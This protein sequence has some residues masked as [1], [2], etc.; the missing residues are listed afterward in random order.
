[1][2]IGL[3]LDAIEV[4]RAECNGVFSADG[5]NEV[6]LIGTSK[7]PFA[8]AERSP[9]GTCRTPSAAGDLRENLSQSMLEAIGAH[10]DDLWRSGRALEVGEGLLAQRDRL[11]GAARSPVSDGEAVPRGEAIQVVGATTP[12]APP[13]RN[14]GGRNGA[15]HIFPQFV[16]DISRGR[17]PRPPLFDALVSK[18]KVLRIAQIIT[19]MPPSQPHSDIVRDREKCIY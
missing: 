3:G 19:K 13:P 4:Q 18:F 14:Q 10:A 11:G 8:L 16:A 17:H 1:V 6:P 9:A 7:R 2:R 5:Q 15:S 12:S